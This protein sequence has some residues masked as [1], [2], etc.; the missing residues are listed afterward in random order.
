MRTEEIAADQHKTVDMN[1]EERPQYMKQ[2]IIRTVRC[3]RIEY[4]A[5]YHGMSQYD[6][7]HTKDPQY[8]Q[9]HITVFPTYICQ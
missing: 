3:H 1:R 8:I 4:L 2:K 7:K 5:V 9:R 6:Q